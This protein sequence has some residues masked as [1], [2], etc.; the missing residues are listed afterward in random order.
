MTRRKEENG[1]EKVFKDIWPK[2]PTLGEI[3]QVKDSRKPANY[4]YIN[5]VKMAYRQITA[6][7][8]KNKNERKS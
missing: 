8:T 2:S 6:K 5:K 7:L 4:K 3:F 1:P